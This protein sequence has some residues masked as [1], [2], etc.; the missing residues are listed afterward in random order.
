MAQSHKRAMLDP[1]WPSAKMAESQR[2]NGPRARAESPSASFPGRE[3]T[4]PR[5]IFEAVCLRYAMPSPHRETSSYRHIAMLQKGDYD[6]KGT[7]AARPFESSLS[8]FCNMAMWLY[9]GRFPGW[10]VTWSSNGNLLTPYVKCALCAHFTDGV[11]GFHWNF[12]L[13]ALYLQ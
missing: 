13:T 8:P 11:I 10:A 1:L 9:V 5:A 2:V 4:W 3:P 7:R 6:S 12:K